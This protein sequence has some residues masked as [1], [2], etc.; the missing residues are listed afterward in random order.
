MDP[1]NLTNLR[2]VLALRGLTP[3]SAVPD[4]SGGRTEDACIRQA[5]LLEGAPLQWIPVDAAEPWPDPLAFLDGVQRSE[6]LA[7]AGASVIVVGE[8]AAAVRERRDA[9]LTTVVE[10]RRLLAIGRPAALEAAGDALSRFQLLALPE[11]EPPH[12][13]RDQANAARALDRA[14]GALELSIGDRYRARSDGWLIVDGSLTESPVWSADPRMVGVA[15]SHA[16]LPF[17]GADLDRYLR[18]PQGHRSSL[19]VPQTRSLTPVHA[20]ALRLWPWEG[21]DLFH[22]LV[23]IEVAP[24]NGTPAMA[25]LLSRW[26]LAERAPLSAPDARWDRLLYGIHSVESYLRAQVRA[27]G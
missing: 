20:W 16:T 7:Y 3:A 11:D 21:K 8:I 14:R 6:L 5:R 22:G 15:K 24:V 18:L 25:G 2:R 26:L 12:P 17:D 4:A 13:I 9:R 19:Y 10:D 1:V 27:L 23:R